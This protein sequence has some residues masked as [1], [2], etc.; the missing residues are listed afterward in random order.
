MGTSESEQPSNRESIILTNLVQCSQ[1]R[2][3][4]PLV[5]QPFVIIV[6]NSSVAAIFRGFTWAS[7]AR[8][9]VNSPLNDFRYNL[10]TL[11]EEW[12]LR[13]K[14]VQLDVAVHNLLSINCVLSLVA[15]ASG[16][17]TV[18]LETPVGAR[19]PQ[20]V[21]DASS[22]VHLTF[23][24]DK[25]IFYTCSTDEG[26]TFSKPFEVAKLKSLFLGMRRGP[27][28]AVSGD[29]IVISAIG[30]SDKGEGNLYV[31]NSQDKGSTW[32]GPLQ[33]N[34]MNASAR[35]GLHAMAAG[36]NGE[37]YCTWLDLR[38]KGTQIFGSCST[39]QGAT[40]S[41]NSVVYAS[42]DGTVCEC[43]HPSV[44]LDRTGRIYVMWRNF[45]DGNRDMFVATSD[46]L[47][48]SFAPAV[49]LGKGSWPLN[50]CPMDGGAIAISAKGKTS[51]VWRRDDEVFL[52]Y[53]G[54]V[55]ERRLGMGMQPWAAATQQ[56]LY[57]VWLS[58]TQSGRLSLINSSTDKAVELAEGARSPV[59]AAHPTAKG[60]VVV[61]WESEG[62]TGSLVK[63]LR[64]DRD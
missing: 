43:C 30:S 2:E 5:F 29:Y 42:P 15:F 32:Q 11:T 40:W 13:R 58:T 46:D 25:K 22:K 50:A 63:V 20:V 1:G 26:A 17:E 9:D 44:A 51:T 47:G 14:G 49:K 38:H 27:R 21:I 48:E 8:V 19:Q 3:N 35:E 59:I 62:K 56:R 33:V 4:W 24:A 60:P 12:R 54:Y 37:L 52:S 36:P 61:A 10:R 18:T 57:A 41:K 6:R 34:D 39:D 28:I 55:N 64:V 7:A 45:L 23:G 16:A 31:W 53:G